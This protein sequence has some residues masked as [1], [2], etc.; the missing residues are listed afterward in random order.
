MSSVNYSL[1]HYENFVLRSN[2]KAGEQLSLMLINENYKPY[3]NN[4]QFIKNTIIICL[5]IEKVNR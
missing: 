1:N 3:T 2:K 5:K 4:V